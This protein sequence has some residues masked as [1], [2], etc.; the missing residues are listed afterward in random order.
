MPC[1]LPD[2]LRTCMQNE[3]VWGSIVTFWHPENIVSNLHYRSPTA[4]NGGCEAWRNSVLSPNMPALDAIMRNFRSWNG[5]FW[6]PKCRVLHAK[7]PPFACR[8]GTYCVWKHAHSRTVER[9]ALILR[10]LCLHTNA[11]R[12]YSKER[13]SFQKRRYSDVWKRHDVR[14]KGKNVAMC[15]MVH[16]SV[17]D[18]HILRACMAEGFEICCKMWSFS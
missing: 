15:N 6:K 7:M 5:A 16:A 13:K 2:R 17:Q 14:R 3:T 8:K 1:P 10:V 18:V 11:C 4:H 9:N 12:F